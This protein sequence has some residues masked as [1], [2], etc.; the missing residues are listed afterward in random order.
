MPHRPPSRTTRVQLLV[1]CLVGLTLL[2]GARPSGAQDP[3]EPAPG[4]TTAPEGSTTTAPAGGT[5][6]APEGGGTG[7]RGVLQ[8]G[9]DPVEGATI[10]VTDAAGTPQGESTTDAEGMWFVPLPQPGDY[11]VTLDAAT[12][13]ARVTLRDPSRNP[14]TIQVQGGRARAALFGLV[15]EGE[16][17]TSPGGDDDD[18]GFTASEPR[19][20]DTLA[21]RVASRLVDGVVFGLIL[22]VASIGLSLVFGTT[23]LVN[24]AHGE[25]V[26]FGAIAA[27]FL[28]SDGERLPVVAAG[29]IVVVLGGFV[30]AAQELGLWRPL[31]KRRTGQFQIL[32]ISIGLSIAARQALLIWFGTG[33]RRYRQYAIQRDS[34]SLGPFEINARDVSLIV[35]CLVVL[36]AVA[37]MLQYTRVGKA[38]RAVSDNPDL[39]ASSGINVS[40]IILFVWVLAG[41]LAAGG[42]VLQG[43]A[44]RIDYLMGFQLLLLMFAAVILGGLGTAYGA[45]VGGL[46]VGLTTELSTL[47]VS[48]ELKTVAALAVLILVLLVR[49]Q[50]LLGSKERVG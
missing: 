39:A 34:W 29:L 15:V 27:W 5:T 19:Q 43:V 2:L 47:W 1:A 20:T 37:L 10:S 14:L 22:A 36:V 9:G 42:G 44:A 26:T 46:I 25:M 31:R 33:D 7:I 48:P 16:E 41:A 28:S 3:T 11:L 35:I 23:K 38:L 40:R 4:S 49:P 32:V 45:M 12:L 17:S 24:F 6:T 13:P 8:A 18:G 30:G 21:D 50:G